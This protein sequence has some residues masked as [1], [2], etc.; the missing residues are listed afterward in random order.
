MGDKHG[1]QESIGDSKFPVTPPR[2]V[3]FGVTVVHPMAEEGTTVEGQQT[4]TGAKVR[5]EVD[6]GESRRMGPCN[7]PQGESP[8]VTALDLFGVPRVFMAWANKTL[9]I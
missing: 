3:S 2:N 6:V 7:H 1:D 8:N 9:S 5:P 4:N